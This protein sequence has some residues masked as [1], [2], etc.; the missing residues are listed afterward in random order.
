MLNRLFIFPILKEFSLGYCF[1]FPGVIVKIVT[2]T[3]FQDSQPVNALLY[4]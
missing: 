3:S 1:S 4:L 2:K